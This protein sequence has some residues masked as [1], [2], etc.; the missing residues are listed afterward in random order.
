MFQKRNKNKE[1]KY[2]LLNSKNGNDWSKK[3]GCISKRIYD[4]LPPPPK[5]KNFS[6]RFISSFKTGSQKQTKIVT[7]I[8]VTRLMKTTYFCSYE[9]TNFQTLNEKKKKFGSDRDD[10]CRNMSCFQT[11]L[12]E[13]SFKFAFVFCSGSTGFGC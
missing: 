11:M 9:L 8:K 5:K 2:I 3:A 10:G 4:Y 1:R 12:P 6:L 7:D 13:V